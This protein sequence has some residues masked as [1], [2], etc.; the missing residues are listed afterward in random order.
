MHEDMF[1]ANIPSDICKKI[2]EIENS[3]PIKED[4]YRVSKTG[5][6]S[7]QTFDNSFAEVLKG[8]TSAR[9]KDYSEV[10]TYSTSFYLSPEPC[11]RWKSFLAKKYRY[12]N[13]LV[14]KGHIDA[15]MG[16]YQ[17]TVERLK[18]ADPLHID[19]W[20][21]EDMIQAVIDEFE[22]IEE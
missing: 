14:I 22:I 1:A 18:D 16:K 10:G 6:I 3:A 8:T 7:E 5:T 11:D 17:H 4:V 20:I 13:P 9:N 21:Y 2:D 19:M 12:P 15:S